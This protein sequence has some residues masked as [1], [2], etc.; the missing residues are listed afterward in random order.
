M[1]ILERLRA[2]WHKKLTAPPSPIS[3]CNYCGSTEHV[4]LLG[5]YGIKVCN[6]CV[7]KTFRTICGSHDKDDSDG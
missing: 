3:K 1:N 2:W 4:W 5:R 6:K 7:D